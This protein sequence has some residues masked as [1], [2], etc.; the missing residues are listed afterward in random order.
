MMSPMMRALS[1]LL[2]G[3]LAGCASTSSSVQSGEI[4]FAPTAP[5]PAQVAETPAAPTAPA[6]DVTIFPAKLVAGPGSGQPALFL[7][8]EPDAAA[9]GYVSEDVTLEIAGPPQGQRIPIRIRGAM[10]ARG[11]FPVA[12]LAAVVTHR[13]RVGGTAY[14]LGPNDRVRVLGG[15]EGEPMRIEGRIVLRPG[16]PEGP[17]FTGTFPLEGLGAQEIAVTPE[18]DAPGRFGRL[19]AG[20]AI[21]VYDRPGGTLVYTIPALDPGLV[22]RVAAQRDG[23]SAILVGMG[24]YIA[25]Y[26]QGNIVPAEPPAAPVAT[27][28][29]PAGSVPQRLKEEATLPLYR[30]P[31]G[32]RVSFNGV[33]IAALEREGYARE[34][35]RHE[36][37]NEVDVFVAVDDSVAV[38]G[39]I[40]SEALAGAQ[41]VTNPTP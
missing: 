16:G 36:A 23:W 13:G 17:T 25:G 15:A 3:G 41:P 28:A 38:R 12:R 14:Y 31:A 39:M 18:N 33:T 9:V 29:T 22:V 40:S 2:I 7:G 21:P 24:P 26:A 5:P 34:L 19:P 8:P 27:T 1:W 11:Y 37:T 35:M 6:A 4:T 20:Q 30:M 10:L 32:T